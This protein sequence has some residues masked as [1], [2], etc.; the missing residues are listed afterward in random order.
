MT[1]VIMAKLSTDKSTKLKLGKSHDGLIEEHHVKNL[2]CVQIG[3]VHANQL[4]LTRG[5]ASLKPVFLYWGKKVEK[6]E[7]LKIFR[8]PDHF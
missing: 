5:S 3:T 8:V 2:F 1:L 7:N 6:D 4:N